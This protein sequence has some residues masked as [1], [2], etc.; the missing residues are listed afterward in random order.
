[1]QTFN[2]PWS[3]EVDHPPIRVLERG[4][5]T[6]SKAHICAHIHHH[7]SCAAITIPGGRC[8]LRTLEVRYSGSRAHSPAPSSPSVLPGTISLTSSSPERITAKQG[9]RIDRIDRNVRAVVLS[10][11]GTTFSHVDFHEYF[12]LFT[13]STEM[14]L[15]TARTL[16]GL[17][18]LEALKLEAQ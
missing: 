3:L 2:G 14:G 5:R 1:M 18:L 15:S 7:A 13:I 10:V 11:V 8:E 17:A 6:C 9:H 16:H 12:T 4:R